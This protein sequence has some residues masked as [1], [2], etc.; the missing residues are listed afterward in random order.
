M[1]LEQVRNFFWLT[2]TTGI[3]GRQDGRLCFQAGLN[4]QSRY[5]RLFCAANFSHS[6]IISTTKLVLC[7]AAFEIIY[8]YLKITSQ[9]CESLTVGRAEYK[10]NNFFLIP[11]IRLGSWIKVDML[12]YN[13]HDFCKDNFCLLQHQ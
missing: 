1:L 12:F 5:F 13:E 8:F 6:C 2:K 3:A 4:L 7:F 10:G 9:K 11:K